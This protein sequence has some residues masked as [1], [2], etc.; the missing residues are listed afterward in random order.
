VFDKGMLSDG[1]GRVVDFKNTVVILTSNL[2]TDLITT[3]AAPDQPAPGYEDL[4]TLIKPTLSAHFKPAL[5][6]R[7]TVVPYVPIR[8]D[9]LKEIARIKLGGVVDR[10]KSTHGLVLDIADEVIDAVAERCKEVESGARNVDHILRG[11][12][13]PLLSSEILRRIAE[14]APLDYLRLALGTSGDFVLEWKPA[15]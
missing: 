11:T 10:A 6:A 2:A 1:E 13:L 9:A 12:I 7:M 3:A 14:D 4:T 5:L 8:A 15:S